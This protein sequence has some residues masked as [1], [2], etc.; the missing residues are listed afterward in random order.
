MPRLGR[1]TAQ[2]RTSVQARE[3]AISPGVQPSPRDGLGGVCTDF[4]AEFGVRIAALRSNSPS[5]LKE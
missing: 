2:K 1:L 5:A 3:I 4:E